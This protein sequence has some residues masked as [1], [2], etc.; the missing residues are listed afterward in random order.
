MDGAEIALALT[1][2]VV[3][4][5]FEEPKVIAFAFVPPMDNDPVVIVSKLLV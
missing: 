4:F 5:A 1:F 2:V 3:T